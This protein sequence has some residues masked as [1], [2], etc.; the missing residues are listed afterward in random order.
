RVDATGREEA[1][2]EARVCDGLE[3]RRELQRRHV[4]PPAVGVRE[5]EPPHLVGCGLH[6]LLAAVPEVDVPEPCQTVDV[7][8]PVSVLHV[9]AASTYQLGQVA[10]VRGVGHGVKVSLVEGRVARSHRSP[11]SMARRKPNVCLLTASCPRRREVSRPTR[12]TRARP[13]GPRPRALDWPSPPY[14]QIAVGDA[15]R[16]LWQAAEALGIL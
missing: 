1:R 9:N 7:A 5:G 6:Q 10:T 11:R 13:S 8:P 4:R 14:D 3:S 16:I 15:M 2:P 12:G